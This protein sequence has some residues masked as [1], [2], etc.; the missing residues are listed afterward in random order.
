MSH[1][2]W[3]IC[4]RGNP[5]ASS[6]N[7]PYRNCDRTDIEITESEIFHSW[8][9]RSRCQR[10]KNQHCPSSR[11]ATNSERF[12]AHNTSFP[13]AQ[14]SHFVFQ[15]KKTSFIYVINTS[16]VQFLYPVSSLT[17]SSTLLTVLQR[18]C[19]IKM[20]SYRCPCK[21]IDPVTAERWCWPAHKKEVLE[22]DR[23]FDCS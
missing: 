8:F 5:H 17:I 23:D 6:L 10:A 20:Y 22:H 9:Q 15:K 18:L 7:F 13:A 1:R 3:E 11:T 21:K 12:A 14:K 16:Y 2:L 4:S 19:H